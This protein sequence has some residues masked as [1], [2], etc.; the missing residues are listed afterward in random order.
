MARYPDQLDRTVG[1]SWT[2]DTQDIIFGGVPAGRCDVGAALPQA[3][4]NVAEI[5]H[6]EVGLALDEAPVALSRE[7]VFSYLPWLPTWSPW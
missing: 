6:C 2:N 5:A 3:V 4:L 1:G 7:G